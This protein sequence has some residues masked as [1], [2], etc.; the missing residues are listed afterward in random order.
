M[1]AN[2]RIVHCDLS[3]KHETVKINETT[4]A[5]RN[6][7]VDFFGVSGH[8]MSICKLLPHIL[9]LL[10][11]KYIS[12]YPGKRDNEIWVCKL[13]LKMWSP[14]RLAK[15]TT[16]HYKTILLLYLSQQEKELT[17]T[18]RCFADHNICAKSS[19]HQLLII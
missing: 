2:T 4:F 6:F 13:A 14:T 17:T 9:F 16:M 7:V 19:L 15:I 3:G 8:I 11:H 18:M 5:M 1:D 10:V 12:G